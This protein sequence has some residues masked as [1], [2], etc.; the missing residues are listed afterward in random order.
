MSSALLPQCQAAGIP[1]LQSLISLCS[2]STPGLQKDEDFVMGT[3]VQFVAGFCSGHQWVQ[4]KNELFPALIIRKSWNS[5]NFFNQMVLQSLLTHLW[6]QWA[7]DLTRQHI[8]PFCTSDCYN[9]SFC[10][11]WHSNYIPMWGSLNEYV[12]YQRIKWTAKGKR[13]GKNKTRNKS[14]MQKNRP[15]HPIEPRIWHEAFS[16]PK[17]EGTMISCEFISVRDR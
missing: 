16:W 2:Q 8:T 4:W 1:S 12:Q 6:R 13:A 17:E 7:H 11:Q 14:N 3:R 15:S 5:R 9:F 10:A